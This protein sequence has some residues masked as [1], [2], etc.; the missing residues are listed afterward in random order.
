VYSIEEVSH[1][2]L[3]PTDI[4]FILQ[5]PSD[6]PSRRE[7]IHFYLTSLFTLQNATHLPLLFE[8]DFMMHSA[9]GDAKMDLPLTVGVSLRS[10]VPVVGQQKLN[11]IS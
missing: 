1:L 8:T 9:N 3:S 4:A 5:E 6:L 11:L 7:R 10:P 2:V